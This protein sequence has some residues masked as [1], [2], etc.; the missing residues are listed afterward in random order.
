M[1]QAVD[2]AERERE[3][4]KQRIADNLDRLEDRV[5]AELD[6]RARLRRDGARYAVLA[7]AGVATLAALVV[8]RSKLRSNSADDEATHPVSVTSLADIAAELEALRSEVE[9][10]RKGKARQPLWQ[11]LVLKA[12]VAAGTAAGAA[13]GKALMERFSGGAEDQ[14]EPYGDI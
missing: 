4:T 7:V 11:S 1:G 6:W 12:T 9:R 8:L 14:P 3:L 2:E 5:R 10:T 13:A